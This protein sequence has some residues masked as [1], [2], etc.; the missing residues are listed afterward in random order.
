MVKHTIENNQLKATIAEH[1]AELTSLIVKKSNVEYLWQADP[2]HWGR[3]APVLFPIVG[4]LKDDQY[5]YQGKSY[6]MGQHGFARD[7]DFTLSKK[8]DTSLVLS[9]KSDDE[10]RSIYPFDFELRIAYTLSENEVRVSYQVVNPSTD[11]FYFSIGAHPAF[12]CPIEVGKQRSD[13]RLKF[14]SIEDTK[15]DYLTNGLFAGA[16]EVF[17]GDTL[18]LPENRF[19][20]DALVFKSLESN[21]VSLVDND[22]KV[23]LTFEFDGFPYLGIWSK[24]ST[25][26]FVCIEPWFG[27]ADQASHNGDLTQKEGIMTLL[28]N[29]KFECSYS[30]KIG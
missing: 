4:K 15:V 7:R 3:H 23:W 11:V 26:P 20:R 12:N 10:S 25:S 6:K 1:G 5:E 22:H 16:T 30:I 18:S 2:A 21:A 14:N 24:N 13:Y 17:Q 28:G 27:I 29:T 19:D 9:L 8:T